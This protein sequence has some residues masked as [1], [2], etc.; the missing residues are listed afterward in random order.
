MDGND[1]KV[2]PEPPRE[3][4]PVVHN[5]PAKKENAFIVYMRDFINDDLATIGKYMLDDVIVPTFING[6]AQSLHTG[7]SMFFRA[8]PNDTYKGG[9]YRGYSDSPWWN[10]QIKNDYG[11]YYRGD[12]HPYRPNSVPP[13]EEQ[14]GARKGY[15]DAPF[16]DY[17]EYPIDSFTEAQALLRTLRE[18]ISY[19]DKLTV[20]N[21][22]SRVGY[23]YPNDA[24]KD[25]HSTLHSIGW[26]DLSSVQVAT[27]ST[28][29]GIKYYLTMPKAVDIR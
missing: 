3:L 13:W 18:D 12:D 23:L 27:K 28:P 17:L 15:S 22:Y 1:K 7:I 4:K 16:Y 21:F 9:Y 19:Y 6:I 11:R 25:N 14:P 5:K 8:N 10:S 24:W 26:F 29:R 2:T 20:A